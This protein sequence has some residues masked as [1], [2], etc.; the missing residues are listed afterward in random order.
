M[1]GAPGPPGVLSLS[2]TQAL[3]G[4]LSLV[5][6]NRG[7]QEVTGNTGL[8]LISQWGGGR[9]RCRKGRDGS[10][11]SDSEDGWELIREE[12]VQESS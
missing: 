10:R 11:D 2:M 12:T 5:C 1:R 7:P 3:R 4:S 6:D 8:G 9:Q